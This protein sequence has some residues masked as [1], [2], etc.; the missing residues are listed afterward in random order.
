MKNTFWVVTA[1]LITILLAYLRLTGSVS[2][3]F[4]A[5]AHVFCGVLLFDGFRLIG[6]LTAKLWQTNV[7]DWPTI[8]FGLLFWELVFV[9][10]YAVRDRLLALL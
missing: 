4:Q 5:A 7:I 9:E 10:L 3:S 2:Q 8:Y 1:L 6:K